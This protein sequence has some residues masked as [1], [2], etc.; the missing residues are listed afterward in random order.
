MGKDYV[1]RRSASARQVRGKSSAGIPGWVWAFAGL[2]LGL[3]VAAFTYISRPAPAPMSA[4][5]PAA[6]VPETKKSITVPPKEPARFSFYEMLPSYEVVIPSEAKPQKG[7]TPPAPIA[8][9]GEYLI[10]V[11]SFRS[12]G[13]ADS[14]K[15]K[16]AL[17]GIESRVESVTIDNKDTWFRVRIGPEKDQAKVQALMARLQ[18]NSVQSF[19][20]RVKKP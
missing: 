19:L 18:E 16:L 3:V 14:Q 1:Q 17:L 15:A 10:Q 2:S 12:R 8:E 13:E 5:A 4:E 9:P 6:V 7:K 20:M 11:G